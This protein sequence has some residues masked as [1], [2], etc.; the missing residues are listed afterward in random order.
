MNWDDY[1]V[2]CRVVEQGGFSAAGRAMGRP[3]S[4]ISASV[5]RLEHELQTRLLERTTRRL[6][7]TE[8]GESLYQTIGPLF[9]RLREARMD[10]AAQEGSVYGTLRLASPYEF[11]A[12]H[13]AAAACHVMAQYPQLYVQIDIEYA[14]VSPLERPYDIVFTL[15]DIETLTAGTIARRVFSLQPAVFAAPSLL[16]ERE[17]PARPEDLN[18]F[19]LIATS[20]EVEWRFVG[21]DGEPRSV[22]MVA[23]RLRTSNAGVRLQAAIAG[24]GIARVGAASYARQAVREGLLQPVLQSYAC[25]PVPVYAL[26][27]GQRHMPAKVRVFLDA[28]GERLPRPDGD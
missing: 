17:P 9:I 1:D 28:L 18:D 23:P 6:R 14:R 26:L 15:A 12:H 3:R 4:S 16:Q 21:P 27:P 22:A 20:T 7:M 10:L 5:M 2:F 19:P 25:V 8:A 11:A 24:I 13:L